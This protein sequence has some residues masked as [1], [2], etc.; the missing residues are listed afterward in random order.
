MAYMTIG[1]LFLIVFGVEIGFNAV[2]G[3]DGEGWLE[4]E[5]LVGHPIRFNLSGHIIAV[6]S[7]SYMFVYIF[8]T[9]ILNSNNATQFFNRTLL[10]VVTI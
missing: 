6:V 1:T 2:F 3:G 7:I 9:N 5:A 10:F 4:T 8:L